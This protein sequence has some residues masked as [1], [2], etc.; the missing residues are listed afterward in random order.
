MALECPDRHTGPGIAR[1][2]VKHWGFLLPGHIPTRY[3]PSPT[4][5]GYTPPCHPDAAAVPYWP[6]GQRLAHSVKTV[7]TGSATYHGRPREELTDRSSD[8]VDASVSGRVSL[9]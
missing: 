5:P 3:Y 1:W 4:T 2:T 9:C 7:I 8:S 6:S